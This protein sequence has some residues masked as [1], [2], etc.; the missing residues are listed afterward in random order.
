MKATIDVFNCLWQTQLSVP[1]C[2]TTLPS[3]AH[4]VVIGAGYTGLATALQL[5][6]A[7][8]DVVVLDAMNIGDGASGRNGGQV[9]PGL[10]LNPDELHQ[11]FGESKGRVLADVVGGA[12]DYV[13][14]LIRRL[15]IDCDARQDGW[16]QAAHHDVALETLRNRAAQWQS[17]GGDVQMLDKARTD[18][19]L[20]TS[21]YRGALLDRRAGQLQPYQ[22]VHGLAAA[23]RA[24]GVNIFERCAAL[25]LRRSE[26]AW[27]VVTPHG[28]L[29]ADQVVIATNA[30]SSPLLPALPHTYVTLWSLQAATAPLSDDLL[31]QVLPGGLPV[32]DTY[33]VL[34]YF[35]RT[36]D[37][38]FVLGTRGA[39]RDD[40]NH[41]DIARVRA[42]MLDI[43]PML[44]NVPI[45]HC[46][47]GRVAVPAASIPMLSQPESGLTVALGYYG[48]GVAMAT[49][50][51]ALVADLVQGL[52]PQESA[53]PVTPFKAMPAAPLHRNV[54]RV[55]ANV[56]RFQD[57]FERRVRGVRR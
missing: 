27:T 9:I 2:A 8:R 48:R 7:G 10:K 29:R 47:C 25:Q 50:M 37:G 54:A 18:Q 45:T 6:E 39:F 36:Q 33:R 23:V 15:N 13:F 1:S 20:G 17:R 41:G 42:E 28:E 12:A 55:A 24:L 38:R 26:G 4:V 46:W 19:L 51:G 31:A 57:L 5:G 40:L 34:R 30:Y 52:P 11:R 16:I 53:Y 22:Y 44:E 14:N 3:R 21:I 49:R 35:R 43:Y 32:S 56:M